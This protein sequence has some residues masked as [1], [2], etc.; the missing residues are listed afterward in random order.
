MHKINQLPPEKKE[1]KM[2]VPLTYYFAANLCM[3]FSSQNPKVQ[4]GK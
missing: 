4:L 1:Y 3:E 2:G